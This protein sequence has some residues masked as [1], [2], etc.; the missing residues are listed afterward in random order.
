MIEL[1]PEVLQSGSGG[2]AQ[3]DG[4]TKGKRVRYRDGERQNK[5]VRS[6]F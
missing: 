1:S 4:D 3:V 2:E 6:K 5:I